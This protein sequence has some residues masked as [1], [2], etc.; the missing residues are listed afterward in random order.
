M[1]TIKKPLCGVFEDGGARCNIF[2]VP[3]FVITFA[4]PKLTVAL[5]I[6]ITPFDIKWRAF[7]APMS[8]LCYGEYTC[9]A[10]FRRALCH[11]GHP[12]AWAGSQAN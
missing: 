4:W 12:P 8:R 1:E 3:L 6:Q 5:L 2:W 10:E 7:M 9:G 11:R